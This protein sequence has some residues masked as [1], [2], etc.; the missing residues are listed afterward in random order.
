MRAGE[1]SSEIAPGIR[2]SQEALRRDRPEL[3]QD[4]RLVHQ[5]TAYHG[6]ERVG[7]APDAATLLRE[8]LRRGFADDE[9]YIGWIDPSEL[10][11]EEDIGPRRPELETDGF[12]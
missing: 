6:D 4:R 3:L 2:R 5:W 11:E 7:I 1:A 9:Y 8:C 10:I 12:S